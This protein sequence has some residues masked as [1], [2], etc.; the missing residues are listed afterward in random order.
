[1]RVPA[2]FRKTLIV[3]IEASVR[4]GRRGVILMIAEKPLT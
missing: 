4:R 3:R 1:M 2:D